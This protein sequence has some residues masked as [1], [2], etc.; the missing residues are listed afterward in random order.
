METGIM[1]NWRNVLG[2]TEGPVTVFLAG[3]LGFSWNWINVC[4]L[5]TVVLL[6]IPNLAFAFRCKGAGGNHGQNRCM[7]VCEQVGRYGSMMCMVICIQK[8]GFGFESVGELLV[9]LLGNGIL[10][11]AYWIAWGIYFWIT[12]P[13]T[14][15]SRSQGPTA[16][17]VAG[18][19]NVKKA[20]WV[21]IGLAVLPSLLFLLDGVV[22]WN[23]PLFVCAILFGASHIYITWENCKRQLS[24]PCCLQRGC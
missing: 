18:R 9:Y 6:L 17:F 10:L 21:Q 20:L 5:I 4:G 19:R 15:I 24:K 8:D 2:S 23:I 12:R 1:C 16:V 7:D 22:L 11:V 14:W 13:R 3:G